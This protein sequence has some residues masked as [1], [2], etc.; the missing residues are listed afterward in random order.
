M[1]EY[2][3]AIHT[4]DITPSPSNLG[5][6]P[7]PHRTLHNNDEQE[8]EAIE[9]ELGENARQIDDTVTVTTTPA[10]VKE[11]TDVLARR[12]TDI[13]GTFTGAVALTLTQVATKF[14]ATTGHKHTGAAGDAPRADANKL[15]GVDVSASAPTT[16]DFLKYN[17]SAWA[18]AVGGGGG[19]A[20]T[21]HVQEVDGTPSVDADTIIFPN[22]SVTDNLDGSVSVALPGGGGSS[23]TIQ[24]V[25]GTPSGVPSILRLPNGSLSVAGSTYTYTPGVGGAGTITIK[26][27]DGTPSAAFDTLILPNGTLT[28][29]GDGSATY[30]PA[31]GGGGSLTVQEV[32]GTPSDTPTILQF[33]NGTLS[34]P[35]AGTMLYTPAGG[36]GGG[37]SGLYDAYVH[38]RDERASG[39][40]GGDYTTGATWQTRTLQTEKADPSGIASV[41]S[42]QITLAAGTYH[43]QARATTQFS[44]VARLRLRDITNS[45]TLVLGDTNGDN[46]GSGGY[47]QNDSLELS[48]RFTLTATTTLELQMWAQYSRATYGFGQAA[49]SGDVEVFASVELWREGTGGGGGGGSGP[50]YTTPGSMTG[51]AWDVQGGSTITANANAWDMTTDAADNQIHLFYRSYPTPPF[52]VI[53]GIKPPLV[54]ANYNAVGIAFQQGAAGPMYAFYIDNDGGDWWIRVDQWDSPSGFHARQFSRVASV[55]DVLLF[56]IEDDGTNT[57]FSIAHDLDYQWQQVYLDARTAWVAAANRIGF[58]MQGSTSQAARTR[59]VHWEES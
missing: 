23:L 11:K 34:V 8:I 19:G 3:S 55:R 41:G 1:A 35:T 26:E 24:E 49:S 58:M 42:N 51:W 13:I 27:A 28:N 14:D 40:N 32:D 7:V 59:L 50:A 18:P 43:I 48:G 5:T 37:G 47:T 22:A 16:N 36:G 10:T 29:N 31:G 9:T 4:A 44:G 45:A 2:P 46:Q 53:A 20:S 57:K 12:I 21:V 30:T 33:P 17:G 39:T 15:Q 54:A 52:S 38:I 25:D 56:K 6:A